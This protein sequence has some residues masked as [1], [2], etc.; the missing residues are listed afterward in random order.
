MTSTGSVGLGPSTTRV[1]DTIAVLYGCRVPFVLRPVA[2]HQT[3]DD[4]SMRVYQVVGHSYV[5]G[6]MNG[7]ALQRHRSEQKEDVRSELR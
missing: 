2:T 7:E 3:Q 4:P 5:Q 6:I 1:G